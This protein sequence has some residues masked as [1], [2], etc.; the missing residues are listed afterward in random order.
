[1]TS[2]APV[3]EP[4]FRTIRDRLYRDIYGVWPNK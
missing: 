2:G 1:M 3:S 4:V